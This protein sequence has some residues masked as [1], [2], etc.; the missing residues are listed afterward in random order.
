M[1]TN[2][3]LIGSE[4]VGDLNTGRLLV[5]NPTPISNTIAAMVATETAKASYNFVQSFFIDK[6]SINNSNYALL[7]SI[8]LFFKKKPVRNNNV[9]GTNLPGVVIQ[10]CEVNN[11]L[12]D[13][14]KIL[15]QSMVRLSYEQIYAYTDASTSTKFTFPAPVQVNSGN[16][17]GILIKFEDPDYEL[18]QNKVGEPFVG[19]STISTGSNNFA[20]GSFYQGTNDTVYRAFSDIDLKYRVNIAK[21][22]DTSAQFE[23][24][25]GDYEFFTIS[26]TQGYFYSGEYCYQ[27]SA[28]A[29]GNVVI[30][31]GNTA[32]LGLGTDFTPILSGSFI[33]ASNGTFEQVM[34][35][36]YVANSTF[37]YL[38][39]T[40]KFSTGSGKY[41]IS[42]V[43]KVD[44]FDPYANKLILN[45]STANSTLVFTPNNNIYGEQSNTVANITSVDVLNVDRTI[46]H[47]NSGN[48]SSQVTANI[49][50]NFSY[51]N[52]SVYLSNTSN[53]QKIISNQVNDVFISNSV[54]LSRSL[55]VVNPYIANNK[56]SSILVNYTINANSDLL[57]HTP[58]ID[59]TQTDIYVNQ[60]SINNQYIVNG[61]DSEIG[62]SG[63]AKAKDICKKVSFANNRFAEDIKVYMTAYRPYGTDIRVYVRIH[64]SGDSDTF[65]DLAWSPLEY[66]E[67]ANNRSSSE[68]TDDLIEYGLN[69]QNYPESNTVIGTFTTNSGNTVVTIQSGTANSSVAV[70]DLV[71]VYSPFNSNTN[72]MV[73]SVTAANTTT[74][75][76]ADPVTNVNIVGAGVKIDKLKYKN[77]AF[78][79]SFNNKIVRYYNSN[80]VPF[81]TYD[82]LQVKIVLLAADA[83]FYPRVDSIQVIGVSA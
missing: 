9:S 49:E 66:T 25:N 77:T 62:T 34:L 11:N 1:L 59:T 26:N 43:G 55:E 58:S 45:Y 67:N 46:P 6:N 33:V 35:V 44:T 8:E 12:P 36:D 19:T 68:N 29:T 3:A 52:G 39:T 64:N 50:F 21:F 60:N 76:L 4:I 63:I 78:T 5:A 74:L 65:D 82:A 72:Y 38:K 71:K 20:D 81:D 14:S 37:M 18:W 28:N 31:Q 10:I 53:Y 7:T 75:T 47:I 13:P 73:S 16:F 15:N 41:Y 32:V 54:I 27:R 48:V 23:L 79:N 61:L 56:S 2:P 42:P 80:L 40:P 70:N 83:N 24:V 57:F 22:S 51:S 30:S 17:Y 69:F